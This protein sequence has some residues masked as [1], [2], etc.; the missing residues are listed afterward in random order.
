M[1]KLYNTAL[2]RDEEQHLRLKFICIMEIKSNSNGYLSGN[3]TQISLGQFGKLYL[4]HFWE[5]FLLAIL[6]GKQTT[7]HHKYFC[8]VPVCFCFLHFSRSQPYKRLS[9]HPAFWFSHKPCELNKA[10]TQKPPKPLLALSHS[11]RISPK[12][13]SKEKS[14]REPPMKNAGNEY[15]FLRIKR[16]NPWEAARHRHFCEFRTEEP[17]RGSKGFPHSFSWQNHLLLR[18]NQHQTQTV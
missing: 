10:Q 4:N 11:H 18:E 15:P 5:P 9:V 8:Y 16:K 17:T 3:S 7:E 2:G 13:R 1:T 6:Q 14:S 12:Q